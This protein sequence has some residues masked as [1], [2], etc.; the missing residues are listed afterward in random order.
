MDGTWW[1]VIPVKTAV[2]LQL[3]QR[4]CVFSWLNSQ[5]GWDECPSYWL[6]WQLC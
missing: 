1:L 4:R 6:W 3:L 5:W 2:S